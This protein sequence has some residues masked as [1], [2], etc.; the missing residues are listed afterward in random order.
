[1]TLMASSKQNSPWRAA[2]LSSKRRRVPKTMPLCRGSYVPSC[3]Q[4]WR[5]SELGKV[6]FDFADFFSPWPPI[7]FKKKPKA[8][9]LQQRAGTYCLV[10][11]CVL[12]RPADVSRYCYGQLLVPWTRSKLSSII[13]ITRLLW[14]R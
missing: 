12:Y 10:L 9:V 4:V 6:C 2:T 11:G 7:F 5:A 8:L 14:T 3:C 1:M 13:I